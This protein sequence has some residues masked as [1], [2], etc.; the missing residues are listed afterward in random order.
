MAE[1]TE[2][3]ETAG[4]ADPRIRLKLARRA[5]VASMVGTAVEWYDYFIFGTASALVFGKLFF[6]IADNP[7]IG[8]LAAFATFGVGFAARPLGAILFGHLGDRIG[9]KKT[10]VFTLLMMGIATVLIGCLPTFDQ[11]GVLAPILLVALRLI[12]G[13][14]VGG[15]WGGAALVAVEFAPPERRGFYGSAPQVGNGIGILASSGIFVIVSTLPDD[16]LLSWG[17]RIPFLISIILILV[18]LFIRL[19]LTETPSFIAARA[20]IEKKQEEVEKAVP[21][22]P[23]VEVLASHKKALLLTMGM[24]LGEGMFGYVFLTIGLAYATSFTNL[25]RTDMLNASTI[26]AVSLTI[27]YA[28]FGRLSDRIGRRW[29]FVIGSIASAIV[30]GPFF[31]AMGADS[32]LGV[33]LCFIVGYAIAM[34][35]VYSVEPAYFSELFNTNVRYTGVSIGAQLP[36][37]IIGFWPLASTAIFV[38][39]DGDP[40]PI[41]VITVVCAIIGLVCAIIAGETFKSNLDSDKTKMKVQA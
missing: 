18:G 28:L 30:V 33:Y 25:T 16:Q 20:S 5:A 7:L 11:V 34:G 26:S 27:C 14:G 13:F 23:L 2:S 8:T 41:I 38:A 29:V 36:N 24:K 32:M 19:R 35:A 15:E 10:L 12:Q 31:W 9:R 37:I 40:W 17:W 1:I 21:K 6:P 3:V 4:L 39:T 22:I